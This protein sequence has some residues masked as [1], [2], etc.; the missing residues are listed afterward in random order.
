VSRLLF[1]TLVALVAAGRLAE[2]SLAAR[3]RR[4]LLSRGAREVGA[5]H[6]PVMVAVHAGLLV[7]APLE[8]W[9]LQRPFVPAL[10]WSM[11][12]LVAAAMAVR[13]WVIA[14]LGE[15]WTTRI[16]VL[17]GAPRIRSGPYRWLRHPNY[18]A[19]AVEVVALPLVHAAWG[20]AVAAG[21]AN[22]LV[23]AVRIRAEDRALE[24]ASAPAPRS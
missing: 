10:G 21:V 18:V 17:P 9:L 19:V 12:G 3:H 1:T 5:G 20:T 22:L 14:T 23:L 13:Y 16:L 24:E 6:Y 2:L 4:A 11:A 8:V 7:A 15:R